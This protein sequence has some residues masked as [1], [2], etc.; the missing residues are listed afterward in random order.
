MLNYSFYGI[1]WIFVIYSVIG[2]CLEVISSTIRTG[3]FINRGFLN[4][5]YCPIYGFGVISVLILLLPFKDNLLLLFVSLVLLTTTLELITGYLLERIFNQKWW[6]YARENYNFKGYI[7]LQASLIWV[8]ACV[9]VIYVTQPIIDNF[10]DWSSGHIGSFVIFSL[11][12]VFALDLVVT[13]ISLSKVKQKNL[14]LQDIGDKIR[15]LSGAI[16]QNISDGTA[17]AMKFNDN[18]KQELE[19]LKKKYNVV[20]NKKT[21]GYNRIL[22]KNVKEDV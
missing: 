5:P 1:V 10:V 20:I 14:V 3:K 6:D 2:W 21:L 4:G 22:A 9:F 7:C 18:N 16:G 11:L 13:I 17:Q 8:L 19:N 15:F 12:A